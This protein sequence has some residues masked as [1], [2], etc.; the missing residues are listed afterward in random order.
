[1]PAGML[2]AAGF[3][4]EPGRRE[5]HGRLLSAEW[6]PPQ[7]TWGVNRW[8]SARARPN[9]ASGHLA[10]LFVCELSG[11]APWAPGGLLGNRPGD[12]AHPSAVR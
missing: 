12:P 8:W 7:A 6:P 3:P 5:T 1:M 2:M 9:T 4:A 10:V 11:S